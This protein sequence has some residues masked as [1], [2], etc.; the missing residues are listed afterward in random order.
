MFFT[1]LI[2]GRGKTTSCLCIAAELSTT[3]DQSIMSGLW[4]R[5]L[6]FIVLILVSCRLPSAQYE[7]DGFEDSGTGDGSVDPYGGGDPDGG[8]GG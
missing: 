5:W 7:D 4:R 3:A 1:L 2:P 6:L 8:G